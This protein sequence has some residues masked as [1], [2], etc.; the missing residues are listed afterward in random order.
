MVVIV[1]VLSF[2]TTVDVAVARGATVLPYPVRG[3][4][5]TFAADHD[6]VRAGRRGDGGLSLS[7]QSMLLAGPG[8]RIVLPSPNGATLCVETA[9][10]AA[11]VLVGCLRN[12]ASVAAAC[13]N[14]DG[15]IG[16]VA[17]GERWPDG[18]LRPALEDQ[19]GAGA[20][21]RGLDPAAMSPEAAATRTVELSPE[22]VRASV[23]GRE[24]VAA[25][26]E[27]DVGLAVELDVSHT[28]PRLTGGEITA[29]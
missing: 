23:S 3:D 2:S 4:A 22:L 13:R 25:G 20:I 18:S 26:Y 12:A 5:D 27:D 6:A 17:A 21:L 19:L 29:D 9:A 11:T 28:V 24:L 1:D 15:P 14:G 10:G 16:V 7:P 8:H